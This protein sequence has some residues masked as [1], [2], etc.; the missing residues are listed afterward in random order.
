VK[1]NRELIDLVM[2][3]PGSRQAAAIGD[4]HPNYT[5]GR[6]PQLD[7][8]A[9]G[10]HGCNLTPW[11]RVAARFPREG[12]A[13]GIDRERAFFLWFCFWKTIGMLDL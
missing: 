2:H 8:L 9:P 5:P 10:A 6:S 1:L 13:L 4:G 3:H 7:P 11:H 12:E